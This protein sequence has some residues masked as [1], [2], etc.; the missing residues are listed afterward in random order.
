MGMKLRQLQKAALAGCLVAYCASA[1]SQIVKLSCRVSDASPAATLVIDYTTG[2]G[3]MGSVPGYSITQK[4]D[5]YV[6]LVRTSGEVVASTVPGADVW[7]LD[8]FDGTF[9]RASVYL[10]CYDSDCV[11]QRLVSSSV[12]GS[13]RS[14]SF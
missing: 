13:C 2:R 4:S 6:T 5:R 7:V 10:S 8:R 3:Q 9:R 12:S 14:Q 1:A 11:D